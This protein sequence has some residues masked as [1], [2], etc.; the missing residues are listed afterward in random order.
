MQHDF[1][2]DPDVG[3]RGQFGDSAL[4]SPACPWRI[5]RRINDG[6]IGPPPAAAAAAATKS[7]DR[8]SP[9]ALLASDACMVHWSPS[10]DELAV[11][12]TRAGVARDR[13]ST[14]QV[15][16]AVRSVPQASDA[17]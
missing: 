8:Q 7:G 1:E 16:A 15:K 6:H 12:F 5:E 3:Q 11:Y 14:C 17:V 13:S 10:T 2:L 9:C 4:L